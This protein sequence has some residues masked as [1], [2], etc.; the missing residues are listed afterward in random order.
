MESA[1]AGAGAADMTAAAQGKADRVLFGGAVLTQ[2]PAA[3][4]AEG[5][6]V[7]GG[8]VLAVGSNEAILELAGPATRRTDLGGR[9]LIPGFNDAHVHVWKIGDLL[10]RQIDLRP[11]ESIEA[12]L[13]AVREANQRLPAG[14]WILGRGYNEAR[15]AEGR[16]PTRRDLDQA[17]PD[18]PVYL[19][20]TCGHIAVAN[21]KALELAGVGRDTAAP[22]GG[23]ILRDEAGEPTGI[24]HET[25][26]G[27]VG[28]HVPDPSAD[29]Y[30]AM[31]VAAARHQLALGITSATDAG[32]LPDLLSVY[33]AMDARGALPYRVNVMALRRPLGGPETLP[34]PDKTSSDRLRV[35]TIKILAD[36]GLSGATAAL[37]APYR[38]MDAGME[39]CCGLLRVGTEELVEL[40]RDAHQKGIRVATHVIGDRAIDVVLDAY[41]MLARLGPGPRHRLEHFGLPHPD[42]L[43]RAARL[44]A[45]VAPQAVFLHSLGRNFRRYL[46]DELLPRAYPLRD[47]LR[48]GLV[49]ALSSDAP[50][51]ADDDPLLGIR[52]AVLRR[53][54]EGVLL[55]PE[56]AITAEEALYAYTMAGALASGDENNKGSLTPGKWADMAVLRANPIEISPEEILSARVDMTFLGGELVFER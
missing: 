4:R 42:Q 37:R 14:R 5:V 20:R 41:E 31:I 28:R 55:A 1:G 56:Q 40:T 6:A 7:R 33:R 13:H 18:R 26:M 50:V 35:D 32:V 54:E 44:G 11:M 15:L 49:M 8:R 2:D 29:E 39:G 23:A 10:T 3:P 17:A 27:L 21:T 34:L 45:V 24:L 19:T 16:Q 9:T 36:G 30:E 25:A 22:H 51:V 52:S 47:M 43:E 38:G 48:A 12:A 53:D 46:T